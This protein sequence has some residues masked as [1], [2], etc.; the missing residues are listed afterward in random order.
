M[1]RPTIG[2]LNIKGNRKIPT[3]K[4]MEVLK[5]SRVGK[6]DTL[7]KEALLRIQYELEQQ[8]QSMGHYGVSANTRPS[9]LYR[10]AELPSILQ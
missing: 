1:E 10:A 3:S 4:L 7:D 8:C 2:E 9:N 5:A 6:G